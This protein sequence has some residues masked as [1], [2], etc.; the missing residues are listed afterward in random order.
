MLILSIAT[1]GGNPH[2]G[3]DS[4]DP[5]ENVASATATYTGTAPKIASS[6]GGTALARGEMPLALQSRVFMED[7][8]FAG[9]EMV[10][11][12]GTDDVSTYAV[13]YTDIN[14]ATPDYITDD[15]IATVRTAEEITTASIDAETKTY[16]AIEADEIPSDGT[17]FAASLNED[18]KD[19]SPAVK[20]KVL[21]CN[22]RRVFHQCNRWVHHEY[23]WVYIPASSACNYSQAR[24]RLS[25]LGCLG[26]S[27]GCRWYGGAGAGSHGWSLRIWRKAIHGA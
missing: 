16:P 26:D 13:V 22:C 11:R 6:V 19:N 27:S 9:T 12:D 8:R 20:G 1:D 15:A 10:L 2:Q 25:D 21:L 17:T 4:A 3:S 24:H 5:A 14:P 7:V 23:H 18:T